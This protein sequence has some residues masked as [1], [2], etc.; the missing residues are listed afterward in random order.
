MEGN[1]TASRPSPEERRPL[2]RYVVVTR[3]ARLPVKHC[4]TIEEA[5]DYIVRERAF[6][7]WE[8]LAQEGNKIIAGTPYRGLRPTEQYKLEAKLFPSLFE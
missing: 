5:A 1:P 2:T 7:R 3:K 4:L 8:V 6:D